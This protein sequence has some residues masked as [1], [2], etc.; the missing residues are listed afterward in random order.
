VLDGVPAFVWKDA[1]AP[2]TEY[3][4]GP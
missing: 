4:P 2:G 3:S 1:G